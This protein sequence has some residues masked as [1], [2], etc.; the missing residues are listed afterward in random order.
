MPV[1]RTFIMGNDGPA[2]ERCQSG[3]ARGKLAI[4]P[5]LVAPTRCI[6]TPSPREP[7]VAHARH[8]SAG[9]PGSGA[10]C[11]SPGHLPYTGVMMS[12]IDE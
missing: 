10:P 12:T 4:L 1:A 6:L 9:N 5:D 8:M 3:C 11:G 2:L 7:P